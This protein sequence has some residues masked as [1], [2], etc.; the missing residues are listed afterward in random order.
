MMV[1]GIVCSWEQRR[2]SLQ[3]TYARVTGDVKGLGHAV[4]EELAALGAS[5][6]HLILSRTGEANQ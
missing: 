3:G 6:R 4:V 2:W 1:I 5:L